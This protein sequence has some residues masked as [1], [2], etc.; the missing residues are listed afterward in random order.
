MVEVMVVPPKKREGNK[1]G[2]ESKHRQKKWTNEPSL[3]RSVGSVSSYSVPLAKRRQNE[4]GR[5]AYKK[6]SATR[7][8]ARV[9]PYCV[10]SELAAGGLE[11][12]CW[13]E[14]GRQKTGNSRPSV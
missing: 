11:R 10:A 9:W 1:R 13:G 2:G 5:V 7:S 3:S 14:R 6:S 12:M 4:E 8:N